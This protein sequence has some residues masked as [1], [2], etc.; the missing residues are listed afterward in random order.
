MPLGGTVWKRREKPPENIAGRLRK[1]LSAEAVEN[2]FGRNRWEKPPGNIAGRLWKALSAEAAGNAF[3]KDGREKPPEGNRNLKERLSV[4]TAE[5]RAETGKRW[6]KSPDCLER[7][8]MI[9]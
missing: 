4:K 2:A 7:A 6:V 5:N 9:Y 1:A 8:D 3:G